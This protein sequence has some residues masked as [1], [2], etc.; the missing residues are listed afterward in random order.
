MQ[1]HAAP[2]RPVKRPWAYLITFSCYGT[3]LHGRQAGSIDRN[4]N[5]WKGRYLRPSR[6]LQSYERRLLPTP[7]TRLDAQQ[8]P[9]VLQ[10]IEDV[11]LDQGWTLHAV[12]VRGNHVHLVVS[13][14][15]EPEAVMAKLKAY[16]SRSL[17]R[18][19]G[20]KAKRWTKH[21][22]TVWLWEPNKVDEAV[23]YVVRRQGRPLAVYENPN[24]WGNHL[25]R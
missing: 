24:R 12:H 13:A 18:L 20:A 21:G 9:V 19:L 22:S 14:D 15:V 11:C 2:E 16:A 8:R 6:G 7:P 5:A 25:R 4:H 17:N 23:D 3:K 1:A 10:A